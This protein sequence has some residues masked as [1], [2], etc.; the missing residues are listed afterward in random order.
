[1]DQV[2]QSE[3]RSIRAKTEKRDT[4]EAGGEGESDKDQEGSESACEA[5]WVL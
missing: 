3:A 1:M 4:R 5:S 2:C